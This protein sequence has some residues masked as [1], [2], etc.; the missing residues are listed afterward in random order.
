MIILHNVIMET[1]GIHISWPHVRCC[2]FI[3]VLQCCLWWYTISFIYIKTP[4]KNAPT[5]ETVRLYGTELIAILNQSTKYPK[6]V[7]RP[8]QELEQK[9]SIYNSAFHGFSIKLAAYWK[10][11]GITQWFGVGCS[12]SAYETGHRA[13]RIRK[14]TV[15]QIIMS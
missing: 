1:N 8:N 6:Y 9:K 5:E 2:S 15:A 3:K 14:S 11:S 13:D 10:S 12:K 7:C 4:T